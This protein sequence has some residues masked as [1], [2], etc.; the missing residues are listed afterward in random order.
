MKRLVLILLFCAAGA[1]TFSQSVEWMDRQENIQAGFGQNLRI[2]IRIKNTTEKTQFYV[3]KKSQADLGLNQKGYFCLGDDCL[4]PGIDQ[5]TKKLEP[6][7][8]LNNL[9]F[10]VETGIITTMNSLRFEVFPRGNPQIGVEHAISLSIDE[11]PAKSLVF[12]SKEITIHDV[13]PNP[14]IDQAFIDYR[15]HNEIVKAK[16]VIH[17]ILGSSV[18][19]YE[20]PTFESKVKI[21]AEDL[22]PGVYFYTVYLDNIGVLTRKLVVRK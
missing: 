12:Q 14:V 16:V 15:I 13:Y 21:Q 8:V 6:G 19:Q 2:P 7:E 17:N 22:T 20:L 18:G 10:Q 3:I 1:T 11:K 9:Y 4:D 5:F